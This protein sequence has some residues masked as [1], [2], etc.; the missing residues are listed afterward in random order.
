M[1]PIVSCILLF[2]MIIIYLIGFLYIGISNK[3][4]E[5]QQDYI[6]GK[7][8]VES[9]N[10]DDLKTSTFSDGTEIIVTPSA[11]Y[12]LDKIVKYNHIIFP[13][14]NNN[15]LSSVVAIYSIVK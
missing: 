7:A 2:I 11:E 15:G 5:C 13:V 14:E 8:R 3:E 1:S 12:P 9:I 6:N 10:F 4:K